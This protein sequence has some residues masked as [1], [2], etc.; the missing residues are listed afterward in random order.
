[1]VILVL[2]L[3]LGGC[4]PREAWNDL[5]N[6]KFIQKPP[7]PANTIPQNATNE[8]N[9]T[10]IY[11]PEEPISVENGTHI[12]IASNSVLIIKDNLTYLIDSPKDNFRMLQLI[13]DLKRSEMEFIIATIDKEEHIGGIP[14]I[15]IQSPPKLIYDN[16]I[17]NEYRVM[18]R[19]RLDR[20][21]TY[22]NRTSTI[23]HPFLDDFQESGFNFVVPYS[24]GLSAIKEENS[25]VVYTDRF[26]YMSD[27]YGECDKNIPPITTRYL[28]LANEG[29]CPTNSFDFILGTR[30][31]YVVGNEICQS[32]K[33]EMDLI[34][35]K[36]MLIG[37]NGV[38]HIIAGVDKDEI[39]RI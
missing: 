2:A 15:V 37:E 3:F 4:N 28:I 9:T 21:N 17:D 27:C 13:T 39:K 22:W 34:G 23:Y 6:L 12:F 5:K 8:T 29:K 19:Y 33:E 35:I 36:Q 31:E 32:L 1:M 10:I 26:L 30:A 18:Y 14:N 11:L 24:R 25:I 7:M 20:Y 16:G 38:I